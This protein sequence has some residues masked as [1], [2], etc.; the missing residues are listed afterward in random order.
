MNTIENIKEF[1]ESTYPALNP[2]LDVCDVDW[3]FGV[4]R[5][6]LDMIDKKNIDIV[7]ELGCGSGRLLE[8]A[9]SYLN[10]NGVG[11]DISHSILMKAREMSGGIAL[12]EGMGDELPVKIE[13]IDA[14][15]FA[16]VLEHLEEPEKFLTQFREA[17][18]FVMFI[19][20]ESGWLSDL[21]FAYRRFRGKPTTREAYGHLHRWVRKDILEML[22]KSGLTLLDHKVERGKIQRYDSWRGKIYGAISESIYSV[23]PML[24]EKIFGGWSFSGICGKRK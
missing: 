21:V 2:D 10:A 5:P 18:A 19:P 11:L 3:K 17:E 8:N 20:L 12:I 14:I 9:S 16:D 4:I 15:Y 23:S 6:F 22:D 13:K 7:L 1:Y 24:H